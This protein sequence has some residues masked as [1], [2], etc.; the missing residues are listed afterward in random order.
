MQKIAGRKDITSISLNKKDKNI[1][2]DEE[3]F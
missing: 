2:S 1:I 3:E